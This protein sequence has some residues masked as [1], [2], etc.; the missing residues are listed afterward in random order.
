MASYFKCLPLNLQ[1]VGLNCGVTLSSVLEV[2]KGLNV[3][4][5]YACASSKDHLSC[6]K[7][8]KEPELRE[9]PAL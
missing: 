7:F 1:G 6:P 5:G 4:I 3:S 8:V 9:K 2:S